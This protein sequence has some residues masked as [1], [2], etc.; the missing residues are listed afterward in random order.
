[1]C[2]RGLKMASKDQEIS[3]LIYNL[4]NE[5]KLSWNP[6]IFFRGIMEIYG[7]ADRS[8]QMTLQNDCNFNLASQFVDD[9]MERPDLAIIQRAYFRFL[10]NDEDVDPAVDK[11]RELKE[12]NNKKNRFQFIICCSSHSIC[13]YDLVQNDRLSIDLEDLPDNYSFLLPMK[14]GRREKIVSSKEADK[15]ACLKLTRLLDTLAKH[16]NIDADHMNKLNSFIRRLLFCLFAEDTGI[17]SDREEN[18]FTNTFDKLVDKHGKNAKKFFEELF[19][20][21][22]TKPEDKEQYKHHIAKEIYDFP[23]V[24]GGLFKGI[25]Y[26]PNFDLATRNQLIDCGRLSW[27]EISPA[28]FGAMFQGVMDK[29]ERRTLGAHYTSEEN[30]L[31]IIK[32]LFLDGLYEEFELLKRKTEP[33]KIEIDR[34]IRKDSISKKIKYFNQFFYDFLSRVGKLKF[35]DPACGC[36]NFL[37]VAYKELR[38]LENKVFEYINE[39][40]FSDSFI[41]INQFYGIEIEDWPAE[42]AHVSMWL[43]QHLMNTESNQRFGSNI[44][45]IPLK[46]SATIVC[47]NALTINWNDVLPAS[48]CSFVLGNPPY[49]GANSLSQEQKKCLKECFPKGYKIGFADFVTAWFVKSSDYMQLNRTIKSAFVATNS[50]CQGEQVNTLWSLL[51]DKGISINFAYTSIPWTNEA[52]DKAGVTFVIVGFSYQE[53]KNPWMIKYIKSKKEYEFKEC[54]K[55]S[56]YLM[57]TDKVVIVSRQKNPLSYS[58]GNLGFGNMPNDNGNLLFDYQ[59]GKSYLEE[60]PEAKQ[61]VKKFIGSSELMKGECRFCLWLTEEEK[62]KWSNIPSI[63]Q[64]VENCHRWRS[65]QKKTGA[66]YKFQNI[67]W[68]FGQLANPAN[69]ENSLVIPAVTSENR[70][71]IPMDFIKNDTIV[72]NAA[73]MLSKASYYDFGILTSR[74]HMCWMRL[75]AGRLESRYRY[76]RDMT[77]NTFIW[78][79]ADETQKEVITNLAKRILLIRASHKPMCLG[80]LYNPKTMPDDLKQAHE[81]LDKAVELAYRIVP[82]DSDEERLSFLLGLYTKATKREN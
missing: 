67:P 13:I 24:N 75:T 60:H 58:R 66:A 21:L 73:F 78:P 52:V 19:T 61:F 22:N 71:Y 32:P 25:G 12:V 28:I 47:D 16:N 49:G 36:G 41:S 18:V 1:M 37:L 3:V 5:M 56:P 53:S 39:K 81:N 6:E 30:I 48:E 76:S 7:T 8:I 29:K 82:F 43:M 31:K 27:H 70:L 23:Y 14:E 34:T 65:E 35:L 44:K 62:S 20:I 63:M 50:I 69:P 46:N 45:S 55:I 9:S 40:N 64:K 10:K 59:E 72:N 51:F 74:M 4:T 80:E 77:F 57:N 68:R 17:F 26:I 38:L 79:K 15:K 11:V 42:I 2:C 33:L 54:D